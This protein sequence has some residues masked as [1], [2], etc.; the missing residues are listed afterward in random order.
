MAEFPLFSGNCP[1]NVNKDAKYCV[2]RGPNG[3][4]IGLLYCTANG[5][6]WH[7]S[8]E[9]HPALVE[10]VNA[11]KM[12]YGDA[13]YGPFY[14]NEYHQVIV[15]VGDGPVYYLADKYDT[16][17]RFE[18]E[19]K[20]ISGEPLGPGG[21]QLQPGDTWTGPH[22]GIPYVLA[23]GGND[24]YYRCWPRP[25]VE[26]RVKLSAKRGRATAEQMARMLAT[27]KGSD[28][29]RFYVNEFRC[30]FSPINGDETL[31]YVYFGQI[32]LNSWFPE[33][34]SEAAA[35]VPLLT[36]RHR[37]ELLVPRGES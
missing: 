17:L 11:V 1:R 8:T 9:A 4:T 7:M 25:N 2:R 13:P 36:A 31:Q 20:T 15:P 3:P 16:P 24:I 35:P 5:E 34:G 33:E 18:F 32:D 6:R 12:K 29:G 30:V 14:I 10:M 27:L 19:G 37:G 23:A 22:P 28:G 26:R 21:Q